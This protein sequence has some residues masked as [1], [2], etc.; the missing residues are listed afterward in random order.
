MQEEVV[1]KVAKVQKE[2]KM[3]NLRSLKKLSN[4]K[5]PTSEDYLAIKGK[6]PKKFTKRVVRLED[7]DN[8]GLGNIADS[9]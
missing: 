9:L 2:F 6:S 7:R 8:K 5:K 4:N 3:A 1:E